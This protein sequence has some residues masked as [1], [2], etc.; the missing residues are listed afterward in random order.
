MVSAFKEENESDSVN[1]GYKWTEVCVLGVPQVVPVEVASVIQQSV[2]G[3][4]TK[5]NMS[6]G[7]T[8]SPV[9]LNPELCAN[10]VLK[11]SPPLDSL[12][13]ITHIYG[14]KIFLIRVIVFY[15]NITNIQG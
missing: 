7:E 6:G 13:G 8:L 15:Q 1:S 11:V 5:W 12:W 9:L 3:T 10:V 2:E 14:Y 4:Q